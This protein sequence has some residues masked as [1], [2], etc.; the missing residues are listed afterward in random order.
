MFAF[1]FLHGINLPAITT[2][3]TGAICDYMFLFAHTN[4][5]QDSVING[6]DFTESDFSNV[7]SAK[8]MFMCYNI[9]FPAV[10]L[11]KATLNL[12]ANTFSKLTDAS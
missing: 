4:E 10:M 8:G 2:P 6:L 7:T 11:S 5:M 12:G 9:V 1:S 3:D